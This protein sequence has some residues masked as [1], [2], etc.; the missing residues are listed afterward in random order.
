M[1]PVVDAV[2]LVCT[3]SGH[4]SDNG[5]VVLADVVDALS[6]IMSNSSWTG[7]A[8]NFMTI[9]AVTEALCRYPTPSL[10]LSLTLAAHRQDV[11]HTSLHLAAV[12]LGFL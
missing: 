3:A 8:G 4:D 10:T 9:R 7:F 5:Q 12:L 1:I 11:Y 2:W 6:C